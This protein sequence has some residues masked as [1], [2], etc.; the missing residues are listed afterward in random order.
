MRLPYVDQAIVDEKKIVQYLLSPTHSS[1][2]AKAAFFERFGF[3]RENWGELRDALLSH[4]RE[5]DVSNTELTP[6]GEVFEVNGRLS[7]PDG[8]NPWVL[9][10]WFVGSG[11][12]RPRLATAFPSKDRAP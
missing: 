7:S 9:V 10:V 4:A 2:A 1:G 6:F 11:E 3:S 5:N 8:R 12:S